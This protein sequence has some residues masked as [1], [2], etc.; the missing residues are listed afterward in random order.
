MFTHT[1]TGRPRTGN[2]KGAGRRAWRDY[3]N[4]TLQ[5][6]PQPQPQRQRQR[7][8]QLQLDTDLSD[9][10]KDIRDAQRRP[11]RTTPKSRYRL[12]T[13]RG[14]RERVAEIDREIQT[15]DRFLATIDENASN[16]DSPQSRRLRDDERAAVVARRDDLRRI[17]EEAIPARKGAGSPAVYVPPASTEGVGR[18]SVEDHP[19]PTQRYSYGVFGTV[20]TA[21]FA[22][23]ADDPPALRW[24]EL[25]A[26]IR[27][28]QIS[29]AAAE[30]VV[31][32][33]NAGRAAKKASKKGKAAKKR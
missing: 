6:Q 16:V 19:A 8:R 10:L 32:E 30:R 15:H 14:R 33:Y 28:V 13:S 25:A 26:A 5:P 31:K 18:L 20:A 22:A 2:W 4:A 17:R 3:R 11:A 24:S 7:R 23:D 9:V 1:P 12:H 27:A 29:R 21:L